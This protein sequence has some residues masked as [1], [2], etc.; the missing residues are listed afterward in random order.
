LVGEDFLLADEDLVYLG[1]IGLNLSLVSKDL[2]L[3]G[4]DL[5]LVSNYLVDHDTYSFKNEVCDVSEQN[6]H[7]KSVADLPISRDLQCWYSC[8]NAIRSKK[9]RRGAPS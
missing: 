6:A 3:V 9:S 4:E 1:L 7:L 2:R 5:L 8:H